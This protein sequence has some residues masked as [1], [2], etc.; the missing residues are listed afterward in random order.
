[1]DAKLAPGA[2]AAVGLSWEE[3]EAR[4][5]ADVVPACHNAADSVTV[6][7]PVES[8]EKFVAELSGAGVFARRVN[9]S[10]VAFHSKYIATA[11]PLLRKSLERVI[12]DPKPR[13]A[14]WISSSLPRDKWNSDIGE[15]YYDTMNLASE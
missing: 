2:M 9:S 5:P 7:G 11:A 4:C 6:S 15:Y 10:G 8:L 1:M 14:R 12:T 3:C 13:T